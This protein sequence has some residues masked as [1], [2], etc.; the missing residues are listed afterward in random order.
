MKL[1]CPNCEIY[2]PARQM[3]VEKDIVI[4]HD[5]NE[6]FSISNLLGVTKTP[7]APIGNGWQSE[8]GYS[9]T[10]VS[11]FPF[12]INM[13]PRGV[14]YDNSGMGWRIA[15]TTRNWMALFLI[16][17][18]CVWSG[19]SLGGIYG[20]QIV[21]GEFNPFLS[22]F[23]IPFLLG[24]LVMGWMALM[25]LFGQVVVRADEMD[26]DGGIVFQ[27]IW[28]LGRT[29]R[30][31]WSDVQNID[32]TQSFTRKG[33]ATTHIRLMRSEGDIKFGG[34]LSEE[35]RRYIMQALLQLTGRRG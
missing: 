25:S 35:R 3:N 19:F 15:A 26:R 18:M 29:R 12:D 7:A 28:P 6:A 16:P 1:R 17:F 23:G 33:G 9:T 34:M 32:E 5:C 11:N 13:P 14:A 8:T 21:E 2:L 20:S 27:G 22:L 30:F 4:C 10:A 24:T 31:R